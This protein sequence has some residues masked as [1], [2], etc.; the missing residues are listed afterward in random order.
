VAQGAGSDEVGLAVVGAV[1]VEM[2]D[3]E[4]VAQVSAAVATARQLTHAY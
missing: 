1:L 3:L 2:V 4:G